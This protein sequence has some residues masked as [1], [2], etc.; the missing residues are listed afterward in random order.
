MII[1]KSAITHSLCGVYMMQSL[2][3]KKFITD[4]VMFILLVLMYDKLVLGLAFHEIGGLA[5]YIIFILHCILNKNWIIQISKKLCR[6]HISE[7]AIL[8]ETKWKYYIDLLLC[9]DMIVILVSG[10]LISKIITPFWAIGGSTFKII[11]F[12]S[13]AIAIILLGIHL[14]LHITW[15]KGITKKTFPFIKI[16]KRISTIVIIMITCIGAY[17]TIYSDFPKWITSPFNDPPN[18]AQMERAEHIQAES[19]SQN[20]TTVLPQANNYEKMQLENNNVHKN[21]PKVDITFLNTFN[22]FFTYFT[23]ILFF[24]VLACY[25]IRKKPKVIGMVIF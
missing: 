15:I 19:F 5:L 12:V 20:T 23:V 22:V 9:I 11:H 21:K 24:T 13:G 14:A 4:T 18:H 17:N 25:K 3:M 1:K 6:H 7:Q 2:N 8:K 10:L 16:S